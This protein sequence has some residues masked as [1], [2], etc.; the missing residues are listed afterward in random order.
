MAAKVKLLE[1]LLQEKITL[2]KKLWIISR[3]IPST[4][5]FDSLTASYDSDK[6][7]LFIQYFHSVYIDISSSPSIGDLSDLFH[8]TQLNLLNQRYTKPSVY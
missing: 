4:V 7:S 2:A 1:I 3:S 8:T 5:H 6:A